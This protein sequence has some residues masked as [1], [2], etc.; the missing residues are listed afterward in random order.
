LGLP[1]HSYDIQRKPLLGNSLKFYDI[2]REALLEH[3]M[4]FKEKLFTRIPDSY[5][6]LS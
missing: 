2:Q 1:E 3:S 4:M 5:M 6:F